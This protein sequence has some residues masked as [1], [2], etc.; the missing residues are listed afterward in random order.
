[1][2]LTLTR[3]LALPAALCV[4]AG[5][6]GDGASTETGAQPDGVATLSD[7]DTET[8]DEPSGDA[9]TTGSL[10][11][12]DDPELA[13]GL[14][15]DCMA[16]HGFDF[17]TSVAGDDGDGLSVEDQTLELDDPQ[18][19]AF[20]DPEEFGAAFDEANATCEQHLANVD[21]GF[22]LSPE[23]QALMEDAQLEWA[24]C[25]RDA[26]IDIPD[27]DQSGGAISIEIGGDESDPQSGG[28]DGNNADFEAFEAAAEGCEDAFDAL[29]ET[30]EDTEGEG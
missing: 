16:D 14:Y 21:A 25:M 18:T 24:Q 30:F 15:D 10:D 3:T 29:E 9:E 23:Q 2:S 11:A 28:L 17:Q 12:P 4:G 8:T 20:D 26:G 5:A 6:C 22:D 13:Y 27:M 19:Q 1:M 7:G